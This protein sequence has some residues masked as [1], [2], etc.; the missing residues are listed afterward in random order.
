MFNVQFS[1]SMATLRQDSN[2]PHQNETEN[3]I[4][5]WSKFRDHFIFL[6]IHLKQKKINFIFTNIALTNGI[7]FWYIFTVYFKKQLFMKKTQYNN[8][9]ILHKMN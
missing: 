7:F 4:F 8:E 2:F 6:F 3:N 5:L 9:Y 1:G